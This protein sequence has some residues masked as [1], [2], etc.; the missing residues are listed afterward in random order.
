MSSLQQQLDRIRTELTTAHTAELAAQEKLAQASFEEMSRKLTNSCTMAE[1]KHRAEA[2]VLK[3]ILDQKTR[4]GEESEA[5][6]KQETDRM[7]HELQGLKLGHHALRVAHDASLA[8]GAALRQS[9]FDLSQDLSQNRVVSSE[10]IEMMMIELAFVRGFDE[11]CCFVCSFVCLF[12]HNRCCQLF[13]VPFATA[14]SAAP[15]ERAARCAREG[16]RTPAF[17]QA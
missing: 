9:A 15:L 7:L 8:D 11:V 6:F 4:S 16:S 1:D 3:E 12:F 2:S 5:W 17:L 13:N 10:K 14:P